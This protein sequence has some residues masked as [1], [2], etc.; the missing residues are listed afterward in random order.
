[1]IPLLRKKIDY[2]EQEMANAFDKFLRLN[3]IDSGLPPFASVV[4]EAQCSHGRPDF[5]GV[6]LRG[7]YRFNKPLQPIGL[8]GSF[9]MSQLKVASPRTWDYLRSRCV[10]SEFSLKRA[11]RELTDLKYVK[12]IKSLQ[13]NSK[14]FLNENFN[15]TDYNIWSFELKLHNTRRAVFQAQQSRIFA[16]RSMI[17]VPPGKEIVYSK[18]FRGSLKRFGIG[19]AIFDLHKSDFSIIIHPEKTKA[20]CKQNHIYTLFHNFQP[21][22]VYK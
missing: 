10:Y 17:V 7:E 14:Y 2:S 8:V 18:T 1:M 6:K 22:Q 13:G 11:L 19:L 21:Q 4:R 20:I 12:F 3:T 5:I 15:F 9:V 16:D